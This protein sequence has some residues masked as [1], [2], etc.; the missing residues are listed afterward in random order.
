MI[1]KIKCLKKI[2]KKKVR[3]AEKKRGKVLEKWKK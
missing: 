1:H 2:I 3:K